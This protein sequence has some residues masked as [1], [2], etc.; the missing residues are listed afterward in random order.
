MTK[1]WRP[2]DQSFNVQI[3]KLVIYLSYLLTTEQSLIYSISNANLI[4]P[5]SDLRALVRLWPVMT[6]LVIQPHKTQS[7]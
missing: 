6:S 1:L 7:E 5:K 4:R 3:T 2:N